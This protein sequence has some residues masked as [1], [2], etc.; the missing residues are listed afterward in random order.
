MHKVILEVVIFFVQDNNLL[1]QETDL[2][3]EFFL[4][5][6]QVLFMSVVVDVV[7]E[8]FLHA[9]F[10]L[11]NNLVLLDQHSCQVTLLLLEFRESFLI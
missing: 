10:L 2:L 1:L 7:C 8:E 5:V 3:K 11:Q 4:L 6:L 9:F